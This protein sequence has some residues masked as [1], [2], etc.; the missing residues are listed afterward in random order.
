MRQL[1]IA[2][3]MAQ[4]R[5]G[6]ARPDGGAL[7]KSRWKPLANRIA[8]HD[9]PA[10]YQSVEECDCWKQSDRRA[11]ANSWRAKKRDGTIEC[12]P[13]FLNEGTACGCMKRGEHA[14]LTIR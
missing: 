12:F 6:Y 5:R 13:E 4:R 8:R 3:V 2:V 11:D 9:L 7:V 10:H 1:L 14:L